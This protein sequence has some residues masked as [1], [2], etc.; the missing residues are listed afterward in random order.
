MTL[1]K[2]LQPKFTECWYSNN[3]A[4]G[5][6]RRLF[7]KENVIYDGE[8]ANDLLNG[9]GVCLYPPGK[10]RFEGL[11]LNEDADGKGMY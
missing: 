4:Q 6:G 11:F 5:T 9:F 10:T 1:S 3:A 7:S 2:A 8:F